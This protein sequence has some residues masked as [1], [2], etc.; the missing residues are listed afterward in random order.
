[1]DLDK[2]RQ[3]IDDGRERCYGTDEQSIIGQRRAEMLQAYYGLNTNPAPMGRSQVVDRSVYETISTL[4]PSLVRIFASSSEDICKFLPVGPDDE[5][6]ADQTT[7]IVNYVVTQ[8]NEWEQICA[9]WILDACLLS[10]GYALAYWDDSENIT[11]ESYESQSDDQLAA[12]VADP[13]VKI[14]Q[15]SQEVDDEAT[16]DAMRM[17]Q[18]Q[19]Q[20]AAAQGMAPPPQPGPVMEHDVVIERTENDG[21]VCI[22]VL[23]PEHCY[24]STDTP[25]WLLDECP[26]FEFRRETTIGEL[27][28]M[29]LTV[30]DDVNDDETASGNLS[31]EDVARDRFGELQYQ[32]GEGEGPMRRV[33]ARM[34]WLRADI[35]D[36][37]IAR[38]YYVIAVGREILFVEPCSRIP[39]SSMTPQPLPHRH[40]GMSIAETVKDIQDIKTSV[41]RGGLDNLYIANSGRYVIS[42]RVSLEDFLND[43]PGGVVRMTD[44]SLPDGHV[45]PLTHPVV[46]DQVVGSLEYFDQVRQNRSGA[47]RYFSGTDA[48]AINKTASGTIALQN[49]AAM[50]VEHIARTMAPAVERLFEIVHE[51]IQKHGNKSLTIKLTGGKWVNVDPQAWR[52][53]RDVKISVGV[54]AGNKDSM[55]AQLQQMVGAQMQ[56]GLPLGLVTRD[57]VRASAVEIAKLAGFSNPE[58]FWPDPQTIPPQPPQPS[59]EM[60]K[61]QASMQLEQFKAQQEQMRFQ[62]EQ[63]VEQHRLMLQAEVDKSREEWQARQ[64][65]MEAEQNAQLERMRAEYQAQ[66]EAARLQF[67]HWKASLDASVKLEIA[68]KSAQTSL[69]TTQISTTSKNALDAVMQALR[70]FEMDASA[71]AEIVR[72]PDGKATA[73]RR[74]GKV[75]QIV[76]GPDGRAIG[77]Q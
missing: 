59:P 17:W 41:T 66:A 7:A 11:R 44:E 54:G 76:R 22:R 40:I 55:M 48:N 77:I 53:K 67:E 50:R 73:V 30:D 35:E 75:R 69:E 51:L 65:M 13:D 46:F 28:A 19:A 47:S 60:V 23:P 58:R 6:A 32:T 64:K 4:L 71:P 38:L 42:S 63:Q 52:T 62:A 74:G 8:Q 25:N 43:V 56:I 18:Q 57:N 14:I 27:R 2:L 16:E 33:W 12:L 1:M 3:A 36:D 45:M 37:G 26:Y 49:M 39:V 61:A 20:M 29:G 68:N 15:H 9:D 5:P 70:Q 10:N 34:I 72:G 31:Q 24:V 21:K